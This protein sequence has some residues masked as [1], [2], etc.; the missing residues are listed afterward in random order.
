[1]TPEVSRAAGEQPAAFIWSPRKEFPAFL[2]AVR[3]AAKLSIRRAAPALGMSAAYLSRLETGGPAR[4]PALERLNRMAALYNV[5]RH[6]MYEAAG[7]HVGP[8]H[9]HDYTDDEFAAI[10]LDPELRPG[11]MTPEALNYFSPRMKRQ[12]IELARNLVGQDDPAAYLS[13]LLLK[14][15]HGPVP[16]GAEPSVPGSNPGPPP[17]PAPR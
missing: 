14:V 11:M 9:M 4:Q 5:D 1:M 3:Q 17:T 8:P 6:A 13:R 2:R 12:V 10:M 16:R 7:V 15:R